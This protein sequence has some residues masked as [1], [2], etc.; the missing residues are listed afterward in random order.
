M[1]V[2]EEYTF[3]ENSNL[4]TCTCG[5]KVT[6]QNMSTHLKRP[7]HAKAIE[8]EKEK[9]IFTQSDKMDE[10]LEYI[11]KKKQFQHFFEK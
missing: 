2:T 4:V 8:R 9:M 11:K 1:Q 7:I 5:R 10:I 3:V 6:K